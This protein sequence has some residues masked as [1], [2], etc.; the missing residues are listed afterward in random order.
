MFE[1]VVTGVPEEGQ[2]ALHTTSVNCVGWDGGLV[3]LQVEG[4]IKLVSNFVEVV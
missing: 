2:D 4:K 1:F 3:G